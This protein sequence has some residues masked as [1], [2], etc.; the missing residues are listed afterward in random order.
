M[1]SISKCSVEGCKRPHSAKGYCSGHY[2]RWK[3][4]IAVDTSPL[5]GKPKA[6]KLCGDAHHARG[7]CRLHYKRLINEGSVGPVSRKYGHGHI[8]KAGYL[9]IGRKFEHVLVMES[10]LGRKLLTHENVHHKNGQ[11]ADNRPENLELWSTSQPAGQRVEDKIAWCQEF[12]A[13]YASVRG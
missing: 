5:R 6:C 9:R 11:R 12:L 7:Y 13:E 4:G 10:I 3:K 8:T 1:N 2:Q